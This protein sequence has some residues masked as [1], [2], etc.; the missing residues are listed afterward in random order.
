MNNHTGTK[1]K[2]KNL[3][4]ENVYIDVYNIRETQFNMMEHILVPVHVVCSLN[5][6]NLINKVYS[7]AN[8]QHKHIFTSDPAVRHLGAIE[9]DLIKITRD[10]DTLI[11]YSSIDYRLVVPPIVK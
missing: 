4:K 11:G 9:G 5:E 2:L 7:L 10:S 6:K 3:R 8:D 1:S